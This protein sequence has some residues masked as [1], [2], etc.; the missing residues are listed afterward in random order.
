MAEIK[1]SN[2][3]FPVLV[4]DEDFEF[5]NQFTWRAKSSR[6][7]DYACTSVRLSTIPNKVVTIRMHRLIA[8]C[9]DDKTV[10]HLNT[11]HFDNRRENLEICTQEENIRRYH[12]LQGHEVY[13]DKTPF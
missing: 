10:D 5:L 11:D 8:G 4:S 13:K 12:D 6:S 2:R 7:G 3:D 1:L 9:W